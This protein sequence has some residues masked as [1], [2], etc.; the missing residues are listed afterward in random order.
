MATLDKNKVKNILIVDDSST[1]RMIMQ[2]C[3]DI[4]GITA[5]SFF[6]AEDGLEALDIVNKQNLDLIVT[7]INMPKL[8]GYNFIKKLK[9]EKKTAKIPII[10][11]SSTGRGANVNKLKKMGIELIINKPVS[12]QKISNIFG[13]ENGFKCDK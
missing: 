1:A 2:R 5:G 7:D 10:V 8:D 13:G 4:I 11:I 12:P 9:K 6:F 3:F